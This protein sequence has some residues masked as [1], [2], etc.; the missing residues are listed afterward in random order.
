MLTH[1]RSFPSCRHPIS[2]LMIIRSI[3]R[4]LFQ[5]LVKFDKH[6]LSSDII[7][8]DNILSFNEKQPISYMSKTKLTIQ[9]IQSFTK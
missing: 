6:S 1:R 4:A 7:T 5:G 8:R 2:S 3:L 9:K